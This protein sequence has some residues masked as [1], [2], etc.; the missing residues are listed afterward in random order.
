MGA[1]SGTEVI[2]YSI[3]VAIWVIATITF[4]IGEAYYFY[5]L[6]E[7]GKRFG[8]RYDHIYL[9]LLRL[10]VLMPLAY[11]TF[12]VWFIAFALLCFPFIHDGMYY[13]TY[14]KCDIKM[15]KSLLNGEIT[16]LSQTKGM[17]IYQII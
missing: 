13:E 11:I 9:T 14:N 17:L 12:D 7:S 6:N 10:F 15:A 5:H 16:Q 3:A 8:R 2:E 1:E 4:G